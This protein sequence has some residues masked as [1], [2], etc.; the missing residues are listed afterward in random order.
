M[1]THSSILAWRI[2]GTEEP[3][4]LL[5]MTGLNRLSSSSRTYFDI[6]NMYLKLPNLSKWLVGL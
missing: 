4:G 6:S 3:N 5:S 1:A 2:P